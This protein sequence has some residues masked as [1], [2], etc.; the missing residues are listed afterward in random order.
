MAGRGAVTQ[1]GTDS[2]DAVQT[3][4]VQMQHSLYP[5]PDGGIGYPYIGPGTFNRQTGAISFDAARNLGAPEMDFA[6]WI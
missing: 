6:R 1:P 4:S 5:E 3:L 2:G